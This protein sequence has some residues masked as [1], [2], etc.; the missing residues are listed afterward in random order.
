MPFIKPAG[1]IAA[2]TCALLLTACSKAPVKKQDHLANQAEAPV[3][4]NF[5]FSQAAKRPMKA[6]EFGP[7]P[8][9]QTET[10]VPDVAL[11]E[12]RFAIEAVR[13]GNQDL[14]EQQLKEMLE[15]YPSLSGPA[16]NLAV[17]KKKQGKNEEASS[18]LDIALNRNYS[19]FDARNLKGVLLREQ[20]EFDQAEQVYL[21]IIN[22]W[23]GYAPAY[24]NLGVL[25][26]LYMGRVDEA[27]VYYRQY[28]YMIAEPDPQVSGWIVDIER[29][30]GIPPLNFDAPVEQEAV[31]DNVEF[32]DDADM[33]LEAEGDE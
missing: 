21:D 27:L 2:L 24:R 11:R 15:K 26:D 18:Y 10:A 31:D 13:G 4:R 33:Q 28:N 32:S 8:Y 7:N 23:G 16:Y 25:Y 1:F 3:V 6:E 9:L 30:Y 29:R 12:Y 17:L 19:N 22:S 20:G 14:A 5:D